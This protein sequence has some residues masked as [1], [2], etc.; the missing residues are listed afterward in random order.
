M[1]I[2]KL[3]WWKYILERPMTIRKIIC[4]INNHRTGVIWF[5]L[6]GL[7]PNMNCRNCGDELG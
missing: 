4:R 5:N 6:D 1:I 7:E 3:N 2:L